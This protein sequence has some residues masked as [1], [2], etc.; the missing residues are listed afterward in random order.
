MTY[1]SKGMERM[2]RERER[3]REREE[4]KEAE[5]EREKE[6]EKRRGKRERKKKRK[7]KEERQN[8]VDLL[9]V[10]MTKLRYLCLKPF[11]SLFAPYTFLNI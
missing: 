7:R 10:M 8:F 11:V 6:R 9:S 2:V 5:K 1:L 3:E 4:L